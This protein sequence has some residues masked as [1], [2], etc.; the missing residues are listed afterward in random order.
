MVQGKVSALRHS[1]P[2]GFTLVELL[3]V[4]AIIGIL[5]A[6][7]LPAVQSAREAA[8][9][10]QCSNQMKQICLATLT[11]HDAHNEFPPVKYIGAPLSASP[12]DTVTD[13]GGIQGK[14]PQTVDHGTFPFLLDQLEQ[15]AMA[16]QYNFNVSWNYEGE[17]VAARRNPG[18]NRSLVDRSPIP[19]LLCPTTP[20]RDPNTAVCD[21]AISQRVSPTASDISDL[22]STGVISRRGD[23]LSVLALRLVK[24]VDG[25]G[26][27]DLGVDKQLPARIRDTT[28]GLSKTFMWFEIAGRPTVY[29]ENKE[30]SATSTNS[31]GQ[32]WADSSNEFWVHHSCGDALFNCNNLEEIYS[33]HVGG[34]VFGLGDGSVQYI[35]ESIDPEVF[36][37]MHTRDEGDLRDT[38][39]GAPSD[40]RDR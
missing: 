37:N 36:V 15:T 38:G 14:V 1:T 2:R 24:D 22:L 26:N 10:I 3:V 25:D 39:P 19:F 16:D 34:A 20:N 35:T 23:Y 13:S 33:F 5:V 30:E 18:F 4:I 27:F 17:G 11:Y 21:Y 12:G 7:L 6:L 32:N 29:E 8:R 31:H 9:R 28:D 40:P